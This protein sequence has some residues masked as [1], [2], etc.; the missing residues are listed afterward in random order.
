MGEPTMGPLPVIVRRERPDDAASIRQV[1]AAAFTGVAHAAASVEP[2][3][4]PGEATLVTWLREDPCWLPRLSLVAEQDG[5]VVG[6][7]VCT[8]G[9]VDRTPALGLGPLSVLPERQRSGVGAALM[10]AV[11]GAADALDEPLVA[12]VGDPAYYGRFGFRPSGEYAIAPSDP[13]WAGYFQVRTLTAYAG[14]AGTFRFAA[15]F[16]RLA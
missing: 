8:R 14:A 3:H 16:D 15:P 1:V 12:L 9:H 5:Q 6:H 13:A 2:D 10:H 11:L 7:V 4:A